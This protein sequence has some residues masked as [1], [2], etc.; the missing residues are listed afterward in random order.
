MKEKFK[1]DSIDRKPDGHK[2]IRVIPSTP[3]KVWLVINKAS[4]NCNSVNAARLKART[5]SEKI[6]LARR[7]R[8][9]R[10][11]ERI[12]TEE[13]SEYGCLLSG[14]DKSWVEYQ[15]VVESDDPMN[16][17]SQRYFI[18]GKDMVFCKEILPERYPQG[19]P[20]QGYEKGQAG[21]PETNRRRF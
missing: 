8:Q 12:R 11:Q 3:G 10:E 16:E 21:R 7:E 18:P 9:R 13:N 17:G 1:T 2:V 19:K 14:D 4:Y 20:P 15:I 6:L 5:V